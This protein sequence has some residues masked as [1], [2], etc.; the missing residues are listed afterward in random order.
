MRLKVSTFFIDDKL[1][2]N[3]IIWDIKNRAAVNK[4]VES[5]GIKNRK[6]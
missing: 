6:L 4:L 2:I 3:D 1:A 5:G